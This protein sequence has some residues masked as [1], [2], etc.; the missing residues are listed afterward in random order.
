MNRNGALVKL[1]TFPSQLAAIIDGHN[2]TFARGNMKGR[3][4]FVGL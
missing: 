1:E 2:I 3:L 4:L